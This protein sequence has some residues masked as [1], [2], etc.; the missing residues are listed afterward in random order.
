M[1]G[2]PV[3]NFAYIIATIFRASRLILFTVNDSRRS[4]IYVFA[5][6]VRNKSTEKKSEI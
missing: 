2:I 6:R 4:W 3:L 1:I 5:E